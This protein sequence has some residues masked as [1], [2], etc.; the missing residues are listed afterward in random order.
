MPPKPRRKGP[1]HQNTFAFKHNPNSKLTAKILAMP[2]AHVCRRCHE[3]LEWRKQYRKY[4]PRT[5]PGKCNCCQMKRVTAAYHTIC[6]PC[7]RQSSKARALLEEWNKN[8]PPSPEIDETEKE[9]SNEKEETV[10]QETQQVTP[11][12]IS[13]KAG[14]EPT[15]TEKN[16]DT[17]DMDKNEESNDDDD[18]EELPRKPRVYYR[19]CAMCV[20]EPAIRGEGNEEEGDGFDEKLRNLDRP[21]RLRERKRLERMAE[22]K[23]SSRRKKRQEEEDND[24]IK[25]QVHDENG[26]SEEEEDPFLLAV[27]GADNLL[28]GEAYQAKLLQ[29]ANES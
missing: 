29:Q 19:I 2:I 25:Q 12:E 28:T 23:S 6:E 14:D 13:D 17:F 9:E 1:A 26:E 10:D 24:E 5:Q 11:M 27:G 20:K 8:G 22:K 15:N 21:L 3:K 16:K 18:E 7:T 4:K